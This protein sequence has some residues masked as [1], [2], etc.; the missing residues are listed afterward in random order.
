[1]IAKGFSLVELMIVVAILG[2]IAAI[3]VPSYQGYVEDTYRSQAVA[4]MK[5]CALALERHYSNDF[6]YVGG[7]ADCNA[8]SPT[9]GQTQY[10]LS[11]P[12]LSTVDFEILATP[13][14]EAC[15]GDNCMRLARDGTL[16]QE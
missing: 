7:D 5:V 3:A 12:V 6:T 1:M 4:D 8:N 13:V 9:E 14:G 16:T 2:V 15:S 10:T 11:F